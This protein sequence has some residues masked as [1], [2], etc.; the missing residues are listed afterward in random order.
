MAKTDESIIEET[1][2]TTETTV[3]EKKVA[4]KK[5]KKTVKEALIKPDN[6]ELINCTSS[7]LGQLVYVS[8]KT[9]VTVI[10]DNLGDEEFLEFGEL[11]TMKSSQSRFLSEPWIMVDDERAIEYLGLKNLYS[12]LAN[13]DELEDF[14]GLPLDEM[15]SKL[16]QFPTGIRKLFGEKARE[17]I[18][19]ETL[20]DTRVINLL[21]KELHIELK[22]IED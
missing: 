19:A 14:F 9:G 22:P 17:M 15:Q 1:V 16:A 8:K 6:T 7:V 2:P 5:V 20:F 4:V 13:F 10:W 18:E 12:K 11:I 21:E 3:V